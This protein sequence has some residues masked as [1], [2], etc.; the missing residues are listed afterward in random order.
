MNKI[1]PI[2]YTLL[3]LS[4]LALALQMAITDFNLVGF[5]KIILVSISLLMA[6]IMFF[7]SWYSWGKSFKE[8]PVKQSAPKNKLFRIGKVFFASYGLALAVSII[9]IVFGTWIFGFELIDS[10]ITTYM[11]YTLLIITGVSA[12]LVNKYMS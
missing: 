3:T 2:L 7:S 9:I 12:P 5:N 11:N 10:F 4:F 8:I 6:V 1:K